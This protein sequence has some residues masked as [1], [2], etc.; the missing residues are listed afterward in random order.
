MHYNLDCGLVMRYMPDE[1]LAKWPDKDRILAAARPVVSDEDYEH[2]NRILTFGCP[3]EFNWEEPTKNKE[4]FLRC[5]NHK[6]I[7]KN[8]EVVQ[9]S[10]VKEVKNSHVTPFPRFL[11]IGSRHTRER[12]RRQ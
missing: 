4:I 12:R 2:M 5:G 11:V 9:D 10:V 1:A 3:A 7:N 6:T 8:P